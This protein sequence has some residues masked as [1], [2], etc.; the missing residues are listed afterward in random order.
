MTL[1]ERG[2]RRNADT[3]G[4]SV[5]GVDAKS[6][7]TVVENR[8]GAIQTIGL[9]CMNETLVLVDAK[10]GPYFFISLKENST[11]QIPQ[12]MLAT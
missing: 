11:C 3:V 2:G 12:M 8:R 5:V 4:A 9:Q 7:Y 1:S 10:T 6:G